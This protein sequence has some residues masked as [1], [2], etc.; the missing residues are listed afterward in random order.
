M[1]SPTHFIRTRIGMDSSDTPP[2]C[3]GGWNTSST[4]SPYD[5]GWSTSCTPSPY[6][7]RWSTSSTPLQY[8]GEWSGP[9]NA[10]SNPPNLPSHLQPYTGM[11]LSPDSELESQSPSSDGSQSLYEEPAGIFTQTNQNNSDV[12]PEGSQNDPEDGFLEPS[13]GICIQPILPWPLLAYLLQKCTLVI[14]FSGHMPT[15]I[16]KLFALTVLLIPLSWIFVFQ[17][18]FSEGHMPLKHTIWTK[19]LYKILQARKWFLTRSET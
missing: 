6:D 1:I 10:S 19:S 17:V 8:D 15:R 7:G 5:G 13:K 4:P 16:Y 9:E 11:T 18:E 2:P 14:Q 3:D 12:E